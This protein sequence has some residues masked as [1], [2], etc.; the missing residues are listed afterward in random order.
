L[1]PGRGN[2][3]FPRALRL[4]RAREFGR[5]FRR[6]VKSTD[7][8]FTLLAAANQLGHPRLGLAVSRKHA[9]RAVARNRIKRVVRESFRLHQDVLGGMDIV[10]LA[11]PDT[12]HKTSEQMHA[13]LRRHWLRLQQRCERS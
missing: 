4:T 5:V 8:C 9:R 6:A 11:R 2:A 7:D 3:H 13:S 10:V 1:R 12:E